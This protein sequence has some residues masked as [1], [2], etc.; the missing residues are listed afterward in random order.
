MDND[1]D[2]SYV[3]SI[4]PPNDYKVINNQSNLNND[5]ESK[6]ISKIFKSFKPFFTHQVINM[7]NNEDEEDDEED[8]DNDNDCNFS[9]TSKNSIILNCTYSSL[10]W[11]CFVEIPTNDKN[12]KDF[13][14]NKILNSFV[15][16]IN[17]L[18]QK[19]KFD[20]INQAHDSK[21]DSTNSIGMTFDKSAFEEINKIDNNI[22]E[23]YMSCGTSLWERKEN[24][25]LS[26]QIR[27]YSVSSKS[28]RE[29]NVAK[30]IISRGQAMATW[31]IEN[32]S[33]VDIND[34]R[35]N[36]YAVFLMNSGK[37]LILAG[38][39]TLFEFTNPIKKRKLLRICQVVVLPPFQKI[40]L[41]KSLL[42]TVYQIAKSNDD[43]FEVNVEDPCPEFTRLR[44]C[45]DALIC[46][47][48]DIFFSLELDGFESYLSP[49]GK[50]LDKF[51]EDARSKL[52]I[53]RLQAQICFD[54]AWLNKIRNSNTSVSSN[55]KQ[56]RLSIKKRFY[57]EVAI[58]H[59][60]DSETPRNIKEELE[61]MYQD[62]YS[63]LF[64]I[65]EFINKTSRSKAS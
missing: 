27:A 10:Q 14:S 64:R 38:F 3:I 5:N 44:D 11:N 63:K 35:W 56:F 17:Y 60:E 16:P 45:C 62:Y 18:L 46:K 36:V 61:I 58:I 26:Y 22:I 50:L 52:K 9:N 19:N 30:F 31:F 15:T 57:E 20:D 2:I 28:K 13:I 59:N 7:K 37:P 29:V 55:E 51:V 42:L 23:D 6:I 41:G 33:P 48:D 40:G 53:N 24:E 49:S 25:I 1:I 47:N 43:I 32:S 54:V 65:L 8:D 12:V 4:A 21:V 39:L 34:P